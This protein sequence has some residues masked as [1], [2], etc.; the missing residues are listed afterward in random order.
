MKKR[1]VLA[2]V[3]ILIAFGA[4]A[5]TAEEK[6]AIVSETMYI[7]PKRGMEDKFEAAVKAHDLKFHPEGPYQAGLRKVEYGEKSGWYVWVFGPTS[8]SSIDTR[9]TK[10]GGHADDWSKTVEPFVESYGETQL[11]NLDSDLSFGRDILKKSNYY[12]VWQVDLKRGEYYRFKAMAE[13]LK[14]VYESVGK[15]AFLIFNNQIHTKNGAD[16]SIIWSFNTFAEWSKDEG[17]KAEYEKA[18]GP[19]SWQQ[20]LDEWRDITVDYNS[21]IRSIIK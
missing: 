17:I 9:P 8:Y 7:L 6:P 1:S 15:T 11:W 10:E 12:E 4:F 14:K 18:N 5:Q 19:G 2:I 16:V 3:V 13:K 21:E 20:M